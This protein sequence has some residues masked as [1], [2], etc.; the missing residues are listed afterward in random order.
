MAS[1]H[2]VKRFYRLFPWTT[3][4]VFR[5]ILKEL[6]VWRLRITQPEL[7]VIGVDPMVMDNDYAKKRHGVTPTYRKV[8]GFQPIQFT[9]KGTIIDAVFRSGKLHGMTRGTAKRMIKELVNLIRARY[10]QDVTVVFEMDAGFFDQAYYELCDHLNVGF[11]A[12]GKMHSGVKEHASQTGTPWG[13][14][15]NPSQIWDYVEFGYRAGNWSRF[16][17]AFYTRPRCEEHGPQ[18]NLEF[19]RPENVIL[20]NLGTNPRVLQHLCPEE[21]KRLVKPKWIIEA[22]H[23][24]GAEELTHRAFKDFGFEAL[25]FKRFTQNQAFY[26]TMLLS[27]FLFQTFKED[28]L[29]EVIPVTCYAHTVRRRFID[30]AGKIVRT[31]HQT[32]IKFPEAIAKALKLDK[33]WERCQHIIPVNTPDH[34]LFRQPNRST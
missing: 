22:H 6:F 23:Q 34:L 18:I 20:T 17:R 1:S 10:R 3:G 33:L 2:T 25:P 26:Y 9:W 29:A 28:V 14:Y 24:R 27:F 11:V 5:R 7:I 32:I 21:R 12:A 19:F 31:A 16:W 13:V 30:I 8:R 15:R 4:K